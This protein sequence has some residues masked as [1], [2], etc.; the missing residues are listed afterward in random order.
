MMK[1]NMGYG[2]FVKLGIVFASQNEQLEKAWESERFTK[3][4]LNYYLL[5]LKSPS[6]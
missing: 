2:K 6:K 1:C 5:L 3:F 4:L